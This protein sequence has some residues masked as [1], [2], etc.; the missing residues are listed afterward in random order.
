MA[1][2]L[3]MSDS[4]LFHTQADI[5]TLS[6]I[7]QTWGHKPGELDTIGLYGSILTWQPVQKPD[8]TKLYPLLSIN[9][10]KYSLSFFQN[11]IQYHPK[12]RISALEALKHPWLNDFDQILS[13]ETGHV[14]VGKERKSQ[15]KHK[16]ESETDRVTV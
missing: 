8:F 2:L 3:K 7:F 9:K 6:K 16:L 13:L 12:N 14:G 15:L 11:L 4:S 10:D 5:P 1:E